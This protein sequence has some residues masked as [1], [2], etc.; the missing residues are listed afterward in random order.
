MQKIILGLDV[1]KDRVEMESD[2][3]RLPFNDFFIKWNRRVTYRQWVPGENEGARSPKKGEEDAG[4]LSSEGQDE[5]EG[6]G[7]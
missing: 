6:G 4:R 2:F 5:S 7:Y 1:S 3:S